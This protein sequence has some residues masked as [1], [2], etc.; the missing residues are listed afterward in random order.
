M[1]TIQRGLISGSAG[2]ARQWRQKR[3]RLETGA[4]STSLTLRAGQFSGQGMPGGENMPGFRPGV[5]A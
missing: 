5:H 4:F 2:A 3:P 1:K